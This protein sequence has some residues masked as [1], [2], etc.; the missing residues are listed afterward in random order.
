[1]AVLSGLFGTKGTYS[2]KNGINSPNYAIKM[3][4]TRKRL[5]RRTVVLLSY[6]LLAYP[7]FYYSYKFGSPDTSGQRDYFDY[8]PLYSEMDY[9][10]TEAPYNM[11]LFSTSLV[12]LLGKTGID[13]QVEINFKDEKV[14]RHVYFQAIVIHFFGA[15]LTAL[16]VFLMLEYLNKDYIVAWICGAL[17]LIQYGTLFWG[18]GGLTDGFSAMM[19]AAM[20]YCMFKRSWWIVPIL[21]LSVFQR[22]LLILGMGV[23]TFLYMGKSY[24]ESR[25]IDLYFAVVFVSSLLS[26]LTFV[27]LRNT[28]FFTP[29]NDH[30]FA[31]SSYFTRFGEVGFSLGVYLK[32]VI[33]SQNIMMLFL[34]LI[35]YKWYRKWSFDKFHILVI[36]GLFVFFHLVRAAINPV[37]FEVGRHMYV[38]SALFLVYFGLELKPL[39]N[40]AYR[41]LADKLNL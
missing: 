5:L 25:K 28:V 6:F 17:Y 27:V 30:H 31:V 37:F 23:V 22:E 24:L 4:L 34:L 35:I 21:F 33:F 8:Y 18:A 2:K 26:F 36:T 10:Q 13:Y 40:S 38:L 14:E 7:T 32:G 1:L 11:R 41:E 3:N 9:T 39:F 15:I 29:K 16:F 12:Y 19:F 20:C